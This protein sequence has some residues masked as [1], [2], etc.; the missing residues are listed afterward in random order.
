MAYQPEKPNVDAAYA[1]AY[2]QPASIPAYQ[3]LKNTYALLGS[4][5]LFSA[6]MATV[7]IFLFNAGVIPTFTGIICS[8]A[9]IGIIW[10]VIPKKAN[11]ASGIYWTFAFTGLLGFGLGPLLAT[12]LNF[13]GGSAIIAQALGGTAL[14]FFALSAYVLKSKKDFSFMGGFLFVGLIVL[15]LASIVGIFVGGSHVFSLALSAGIILL[16]SGYILYDTSRIIHGGET[17]YIMA[18]VALYL[19]IYNIFVSLLHILGMTSD[20]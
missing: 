1:D 19:D 10:F 17:N 5:L 11:Q 14:I 2:Q 4:T 15:L 3:V 12:Y 7:A 8:I 13:E 6:I 16:F 20:D 18:T 9:A